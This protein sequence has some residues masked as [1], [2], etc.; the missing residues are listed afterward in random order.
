MKNNSNLERRI[1]VLDSCWKDK[2]ENKG[3]I[4]YDLNRGGLE[5]SQM[6]FANNYANAIKC[7]ESCGKSRFMAAVI[8]PKVLASF[9]D[10][11]KG[12][13]RRA[14]DN[15][16]WSREEEW[17][18]YQNAVSEFIKT[19]E[20][21][22]LLSHLKLIELLRVDNPEIEIYYVCPIGPQMD[23]HIYHDGTVLPM[24]L[25]GDKEKNPICQVGKHLNNAYF[26]KDSCLRRILTK[27]HF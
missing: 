20:Q 14:L 4:G 27:L 26:K 11:T 19:F 21:K 10:V 17:T 25:G 3:L 8:E 13:N 22:R 7:I 6:V 15:P 2:P 23:N 1:L 9:D 12:V 18:N 16:T 24:A 5:E